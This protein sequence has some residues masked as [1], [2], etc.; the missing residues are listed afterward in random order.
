MELKDILTL[1]MALIGG[2]IG[3]YATHQTGYE[4]WLR[5]RRSDVFAKFLETVEL[6][7]SKA[8]NILHE[9]DLE[10][11]D[12]GIKMHEAYQSVFIQTRIVR[13]YL[14][15]SLRTEFS[16]LMKKYWSL[17]ST[18]ELGNSRIGKMD[19]V[20]TRVQEMFEAQLVPHFWLHSAALHI[21]RKD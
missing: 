5:E 21:L 18:P 12:Q 1:V 10:T 17:H 2:A 3:A 6:V 7:F 20:L 15:S 4:K 16:E 19:L 11:V 14:P 13:L 8:T 9:R